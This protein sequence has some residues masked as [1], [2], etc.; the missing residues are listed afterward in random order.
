MTRAV[1]AEVALVALFAGACIDVPDFADP[2]LIDRPRVLAVIAD[3]PEV[4]PGDPVQLSILVAGAE[5]YEVSWRACGAF[6]S[7]FGGGSQYGDEQG[8][9]GCGGG[10]ALELGDGERA[11]LPGEATQTLFDNLDLAAEILGAALPEGTIDRIREDVGLPFT[12]EATVRADGRMIRAVKRVLISAR[13]EPHGNP[14]PPAFTLDDIEVSALAQQPG[15]AP[16][17]VCEREDGGEIRLDAD[18][19]VELAPIVRSDDGVEPWLES[20]QVIDVRG[21]LRSRTETAF[22]SWFSTGG[23]LTEGVTKS[24]L[25]N[26]IWRTPVQRGCHSLWLVIRDGHGGSS[27]C[28]VRVAVSSARCD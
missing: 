1:L 10:F 9:E 12:V 24:P 15:E 21:E 6:D 18:S 17:F 19:D 16:T 5:R 4:N 8:D 13:A 14:P 2:S 23:S 11:V 20:Y 7:F 27:A 22:Y 28:A 26:E 3:P 25:R